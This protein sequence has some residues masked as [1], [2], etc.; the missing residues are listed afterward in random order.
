[1]V[2]IIIVSRF[3]VDIG[4]CRCISCCISQ[5]PSARRGQSH[6]QSRGRVVHVDLWSYILRVQLWHRCKFGFWRTRFLDSFRSQNMYG[7]LKKLLVD[8]LFL[9]PD[10]CFSFWGRSPL[11]PVRT[12]SRADMLWKDVMLAVLPWQVEQPPARRPRA[13]ASAPRAPPTTAPFRNV[14]QNRGLM[15]IL[16]EK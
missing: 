3:W 1:M 16:L 12:I 10:P 14:E 13:A 4:G 2:H 15:E 5:L 11:S 9:A 7:I 8:V 6:G